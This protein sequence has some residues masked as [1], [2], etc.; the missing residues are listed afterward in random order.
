VSGPKIIPKSKDTITNGINNFVTL[1][2]KVVR[3]AS[4]TLKFI[5]FYKKAKKSLSPS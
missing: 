3:L 1:F 2:R 4:V 5:Y